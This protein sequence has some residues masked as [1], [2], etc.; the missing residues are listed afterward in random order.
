MQILE[1]VFGSL[2]CLVIGFLLGYMLGYI[3]GNKNY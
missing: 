3:A 1:L 2:L